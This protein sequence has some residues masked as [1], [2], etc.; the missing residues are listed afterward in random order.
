MH[1]HAPALAFGGAGRRLSGVYLD[2]AWWF[3]FSKRTSV[4]NVFSETDIEGSNTEFYSCEVYLR[5]YRCIETRTRRECRLH[6]CIN[7]ERLTGYGSEG[8]QWETLTSE[9]IVSYDR[10][11]GYVD[12]DATV[13]R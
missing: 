9:Y 11:K 4:L 7:G 3:H 12:D 2:D 10:L 6:I 13:I 8:L 1:A 5:A